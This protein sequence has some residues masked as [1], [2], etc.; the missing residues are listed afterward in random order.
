MKL[1]VVIVCY[2]VPDLTIKC[3]RSL[4]A[5]VLALPDSRVA[6]CENGTGVDSYER[7]EN[8]IKQNGWGSWVDL[9][10]VMPN[11]GFTGGNNFVIGPVLASKDPPEYVLLLNADTEIY[12][13][14]LKALIKF[15]DAHPRVGV[16]GSQLLSPDGIIQP[17][18]FQ[19]E[20]IASQFNRGVRIGAV[21]R[22]L[23]QWIKPPSQAEACPAGWVA[24]AS[25]I[26]RRQVLQQVGLLD[27][28]YF[29][30]YDDIDYCLNTWR[31]GWEVWYVPESRV[32]HLE[33]SSTG[34]SGI[35][36]GKRP[37]RKPAYWFEARRR[38]F[39]KNY[40]ALYTACVDAAFIL[41]FAIWR[42]RR[43]IQRSPDFDPPFLLMDSICHSVFVTGFKF[44]DVNNP[45]TN[46]P[47]T[48]AAMNNAA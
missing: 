37:N 45:A 28:G 32:M 9:S 43:I 12:P 17:S 18:P 35:K 13:G 24:G 5:E 27:E 44:R 30:Y 38:Y 21:S 31:G 40:G 22:L 6:V 41:G 7:L 15:M 47:L 14:A 46:R 19:F 26:I 8:A 48:A 23:S 34:V 36:G 39:L 11:L 3:L 29:T 42:L 2:K 1:L 25:M 4:E 20:G 10:S 16:A 33:G